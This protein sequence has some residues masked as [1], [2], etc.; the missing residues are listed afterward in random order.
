[1]QRSECWGEHIHHLLK[2][3]LLRKSL[4][5]K[6]VD[7]LPQHACKHLTVVKSIHR[8]ISEWKRKCASVQTTLRKGGMVGE[9]TKMLSFKNQALLESGRS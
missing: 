8:Q 9:E 7:P 1:M 4:H 3:R 2:Y 5:L 6:S